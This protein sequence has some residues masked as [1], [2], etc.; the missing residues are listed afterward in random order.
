MNGL[1]E[2]A[3]SAA[4]GLVSFLRVPTA[5]GSSVSRVAVQV[6]VYADS[7]VSKGLT[8]RSCALSI[9]RTARADGV[10]LD[11]E[12]AAIVRAAALR[13]QVVPGAALPGQARCF[14]TTPALL[15]RTCKTPFVW[16]IREV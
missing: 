16:A 2:L 1:S 6:Q 10:L 8:I 9:L 4:A 14:K 12:R 7:R 5:C 15:A 13:P 3:Q 11:P